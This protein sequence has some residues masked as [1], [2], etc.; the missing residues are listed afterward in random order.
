M[1]WT[2]DPPG[3]DEKVAAQAVAIAR[4]VGRLAFPQDVGR[5][6]RVLLLFAVEHDDAVPIPNDCKASHAVL[7]F[8]LVPKI[9]NRFYSVGSSGAGTSLPS[10]KNQGLGMTL[11]GCAK[12][13]VRV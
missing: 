5:A 9:V 10:A 11:F 6:V 4:L 7:L 2:P 3:Q 8:C 1:L 12:S 13:V